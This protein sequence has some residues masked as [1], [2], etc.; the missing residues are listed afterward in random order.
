M[1]V[2]CD[3]ENAKC[4]S[5][6]IVVH[7]FT[8]WYRASCSEIYQ[9]QSAKRQ[10]RATR[11]TQTRA[12]F[13]FE[14]VESTLQYTLN[15]SL[16]VLLTIVEICANILALTAISHSTSIGLSNFYTVVLADVGVDLVFQPQFVT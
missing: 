15:S 9:Q 2:P 8:I 7:S 16:N 11:T 12:L 10:Q 3:V 13:Y 14:T 5:W 6:V 1:L 4:F